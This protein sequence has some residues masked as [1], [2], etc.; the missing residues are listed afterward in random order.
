MCLLESLIWL[1]ALDLWVHLGAPALAAVEGVTEAQQVS[2]VLF[3][4][5]PKEV[6]I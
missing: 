1:Q 3:K 6:S 4:S 5:T 2:L